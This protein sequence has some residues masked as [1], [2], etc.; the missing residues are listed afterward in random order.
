MPEETNTNE[1]I[2][3]NNKVLQYG[4]L[5]DENGYQVYLYPGM[6]VAEIAFNVM[7]TIRLLEKDGYIKDKAEFDA[8]IEKYYT[9]P[10]YAPLEEV[11]D[12]QN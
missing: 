5:S 8:L 1:K 7:V 2:N 6:T 9:D 11:T 10:Q 4:V 12:G 3:I